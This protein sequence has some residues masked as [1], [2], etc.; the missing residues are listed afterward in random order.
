MSILSCLPEKAIQNIVTYTISQ[1]VTKRR[2]EER[3]TENR[4]T[5]YLRLS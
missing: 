2:K 4:R 1:T 5:M 3:R